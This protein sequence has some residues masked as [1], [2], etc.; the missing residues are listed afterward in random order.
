[1]IERVTYAINAINIHY[2][3]CSCYAFTSA[4]AQLCYFQGSQKL[5]GFGQTDICGSKDDPTL[6]CK[7]PS[8]CIACSYW[9]S[10]ACLPMKIQVHSQKIFLG[11]AFEE[12]VD[13]LILYMYHSL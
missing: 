5:F 3:F 9:G 4:V 1:M 13:L 11:S 7:A 10:E 6:V 2:L 12:K 8:A